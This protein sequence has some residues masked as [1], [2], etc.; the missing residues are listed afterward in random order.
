MTN[1]SI[2]EAKDI[3]YDFINA[4]EEMEEAEQPNETGRVYQSPK[5]RWTVFV[6]FDNMVCPVCGASTVIDTSRHTPREVCLCGA[7]RYINSDVW[8]IAHKAIT[9]A[10]DKEKV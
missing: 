6:E 1:E 4:V 8:S 2:K 7:R 5:H 9:K 3:A 10:D